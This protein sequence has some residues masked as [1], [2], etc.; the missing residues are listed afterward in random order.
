MNR[1]GREL[2]RYAISGKPP[3]S[4]LSQDARTYFTCVL[5]VP[6]RRH[7]LLL[8]NVNEERTIRH[9]HS[10]NSVGERRKNFN[11]KIVHDEECADA[12]T[13]SRA[14]KFEYSE[15][16]DESELSGLPVSDKEGDW[17]TELEWVKS[18]ETRNVLL[19]P[20]DVSDIDVLAPEL[21]PSFNFAAYVN[22]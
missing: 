3:L 22:K 21:L 6:L 4:P 11:D 18:R 12:E 19:P 8:C 14:V 7:T 20:K 9:Q 1:I 17:T 10:N 13:K 15:L 16:I 2:V 5:Q